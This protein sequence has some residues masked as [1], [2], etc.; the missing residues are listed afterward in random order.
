MRATAARPVPLI[1]ALTL[2]LAFLPFGPAHL[3]EAQADGARPLP[4]EGGPLEPGRYRTLVVGPELSFEVGDSW[5]LVQPVAG[6]LV[7]LERVDIPAAVMTITRFDGDAFAD[8]CDPTSLTFV[9]PS[10]ERLIDII[11]GDPRLSSA[12]PAA[13]QVDGL[14]AISIDVSTPPLEDCSLPFLL[15]WALQMEGGEFVQVPGQQARFIALD[16]GSDVIVVAIETFV[17]EP[18]GFFGAAASAVVDSLRFGTAADEP[19]ASDA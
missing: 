5:R 15:I 6:P 3:A 4:A 18:F 19:P 11:A 17:E 2:A 10:A 14:P 13:T 16:V 7:V 9:E 12:M 1:C 8:S